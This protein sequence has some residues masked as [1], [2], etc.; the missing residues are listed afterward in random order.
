MVRLAPIQRSLHLFT[1]LLDVNVIEDII[2]HDN[3]I[4]GYQGF[5][6]FSK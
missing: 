3:F 1:H 5:V 2:G 4:K 6:L